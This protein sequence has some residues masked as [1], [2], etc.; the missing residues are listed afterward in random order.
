MTDQQFNNFI[1][2]IATAKIGHDPANNINRCNPYDPEHLSDLSMFNLDL[3]HFCFLPARP[4]LI[5]PYTT[6]ADELNYQCAILIIK[7]TDNTQPEIDA[8][9]NGAEVIALKMWAYFK[10]L[11]QTNGVFLFDKIRMAKQPF[12]IEKL[13]G[14]SENSAGVEIIFTL[15]EL[16]YYHH[17]LDVAVWQ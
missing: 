10:E 5:V 7:M 13:K 2:G 8:A 11:E 17:Y 16:I 15:Q 1:A 4:D 12:R 6:G 3:T 14:L 9:I